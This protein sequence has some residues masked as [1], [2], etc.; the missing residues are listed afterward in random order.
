MPSR[1]Q[2]KLLNSQKRLEVIQNLQQQPDLKPDD[3]MLLKD[4]EKSQMQ[5]LALRQ[6]TAENENPQ[7]TVNSPVA[8]P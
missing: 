3:Q 5:A 7:P 1:A 6:K 8:N 4:L 2:M